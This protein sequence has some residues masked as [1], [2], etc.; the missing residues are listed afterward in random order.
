MVRNMFP[1]L[2]GHLRFHKARGSCCY[3]VEGRRSLYKGGYTK[4]VQA[5]SDLLHCKLSS[6]QRGCLRWSG[7]YKN[8]RDWCSLIPPD[9]LYSIN[10]FYWALCT[11]R[12]SSINENKHM[13]GIVDDI[14]PIS[15]DKSTVRQPEISD[16]HLHTPCDPWCIENSEN[17]FCH[18]SLS[19]MNGAFITL[20]MPP[21]CCSSFWCHLCCEWHSSDARS[22]VAIDCHYSMNHVIKPPSRRLPELTRNWSTMS[23]P[24]ALSIWRLQ[25]F[26]PI[27]WINPTIET[28]CLAR[29]TISRTEPPSLDPPPSL[30]RL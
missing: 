19:S 14:K 2:A 21:I 3:N 24:L 17:S 11:T 22:F 12:R 5:S 16:S 7:I 29:W 23:K 26:F 28:Y 1:S 8:M 9:K 10:Y 4:S 27:F 18:I 6:Q 15:S 13:L 20:P 30:V 25:I